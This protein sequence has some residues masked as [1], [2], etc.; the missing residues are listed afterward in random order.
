MQTAS[1]VLHASITG[2]HFDGGKLQEHTGGMQQWDDIGELQEVVQL[3]YG[4]AAEV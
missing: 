1:L 2:L 3:H 4:S